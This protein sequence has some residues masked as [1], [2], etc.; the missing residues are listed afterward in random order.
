MMPTPTGDGAEQVT[1]AKPSFRHPILTVYATALVV[2]QGLDV[3]LTWLLL[4]G[5]PTVEANPVAH[6]L[7]NGSYLRLAAAKLVGSAVVAWLAFQMP[8]TRLG[9]TC[10]VLGLALPVAIMLAVVLWDSAMLVLVGL[11]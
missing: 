9:R 7:I 8:P 11:A 3:L 2:L 10:A 4:Q 6:F 1:F 5:G